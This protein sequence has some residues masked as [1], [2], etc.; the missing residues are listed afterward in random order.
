VITKRRC[1]HTGIVNFYGKADPLLA[2]GSVSEG[3]MP[4]QFI[5]RSYLGNPAGGVAPDRSI[6][7]GHLRDAIAR[8]QDPNQGLI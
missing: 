5:W 6:A 1:P 2:I 7:E 8:A 4:A 3:A